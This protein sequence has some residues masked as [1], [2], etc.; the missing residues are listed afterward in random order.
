MSLTPSRSN[1]NPTISQG[2]RND[3]MFL[4]VINEI[5]NLITNLIINFLTNLIQILFLIDVTEKDLPGKDV[6]D[7]DLPDKDV[8]DKD[9]PD[10]DVTQNFL[11]S[12]CCKYC[13][14]CLVSGNDAH[15]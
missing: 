14:I 5:V 2:N 6:T 13:I 11:V 3:K 12:A 1:L 7:K 15:D 10:T 4:K 9:F 8:T